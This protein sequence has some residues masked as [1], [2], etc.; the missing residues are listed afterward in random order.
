MDQLTLLRRRRTVARLRVSATVGHGR[1]SHVGA[2]HGVAVRWRGTVGHGLLSETATT[3]EATTTT[4]TTSR[5]IV[6]GLVYA[7]DSTVEPIPVLAPIQLLRRRDAPVSVRGKFVLDIVHGRDGILGIALLGVANESETAAATS[8]SI[9]DN[10]L[11]GVKS[12][13]LRCLVR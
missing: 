5:T 2:A 1:I 12:A 8:V 4:E 9:L 3:T 10:D 7:N 6:R 11:D 13:K